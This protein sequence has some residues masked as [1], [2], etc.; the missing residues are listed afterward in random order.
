MGYKF[1]ADLDLNVGQPL[2]CKTFVRKTLAKRTQPAVFCLVRMCQHVLLKTREK[3][4]P[5]L[6]PVCRFLSLDSLRGS[7]LSFQGPIT[8]NVGRDLRFVPL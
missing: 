5:V 6:T 1:H 3:T 7:R 8:Q 4:W 2:N